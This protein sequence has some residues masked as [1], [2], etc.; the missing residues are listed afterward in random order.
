[1]KIRPSLRLS[2]RGFISI[3]C[4]GYLI[5]IALLFAG[6]QGI[7]TALKNREPLVI[8][9]KDYLAK[10]PDAEWVTLQGATLNLLESAHRESIT[11]K[12]EE[13]FIP[14]RAGM[15]DRG[16]VKVLL[17]TKDQDTIAAMHS[18]S[19]AGAKGGN[20][21]DVIKAVAGNASQVFR[22]R[23]VSGLVRFGID[24]DSKTRAKLAGL[25]MKL[26]K[27]FIILDEG[28]KPE[29]GL[30]V[31]LFAMGLIGAF[32]AFKRAAKVEATAPPPPPPPNL[33]ARE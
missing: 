13:V 7:Y 25:Q 20:E 4:M 1:M 11:G 2:S 17:S 26:A 29:L 32:I 23:D 22:V 16:P 24:A 10:P 9:A 19:S 14:I 15:G 28:K 3:G 5:V 6:G 18:I 8:P 21:A 30:S 31:S 33:P 27:D 12:I